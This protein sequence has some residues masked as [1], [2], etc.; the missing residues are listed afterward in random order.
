MDGLHS[1]LHTTL[2]RLILI[3]LFPT[4]SSISSLHLL[5]GFPLALLQSLGYHSVVILA[6][7]LSSVLATCPAH[8]LFR[9]LVVLMTSFTLVLSMIVSFLI[10]SFRLIFRMLL[11]ILLCVV[12]YFL[13]WSFVSAHVSAP[14]I[15]VGKMTVSIIFF[16]RLAGA[17]LS[18]K[19]WLYWPNLHTGFTL[20]LSSTLIS[21]FGVNAFP[22]YLYSSI[23]SSFTPST[24]FHSS[25]AS[26]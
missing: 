22:R 14:Y 9:S 4:F 23:S 26:L 16:L 6:Y 1:C 19:K 8:L 5:F 20:W 18:S 15:K 13:D 7:L 12:A 25:V 21:F 10:L 2:S 24:E 11:S 17:F 3:Q